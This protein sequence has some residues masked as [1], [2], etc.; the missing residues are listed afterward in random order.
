MAK[1]SL[2]PY[3]KATAP[4]TEVLAEL[5]QN[6]ES[7]FISYRIQKGLPLV[8]L[9]SSTPHKERVLKL[10]EKTCFELF[11]KNEKDSYVEFNFSPNFEWNCFYFAKKGDPLEEWT[12][13]NRPATEILLS[14]DHYFLFA[15]IRKELFPVGFFDGTHE[16][17]CGISSVIKGPNGVLSYWALSHHDTRPNFHDFRSFEKIF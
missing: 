6:E 5:N 11:I 15:E 12:R 4:A 1:F 17:R 10:W 7:V 9:G 8:D 14:L 3:N 13:M 16:L 2:T